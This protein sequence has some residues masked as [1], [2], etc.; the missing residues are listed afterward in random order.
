MR[1]R[2]SIPPL[3][4]GLGF[5]ALA[6]AAWVLAAS[7][8]VNHLRALRWVAIPADLISLRRDEGALDQRALARH[9]GERLVGRYRYAVDGRVFEST[10]ISFSH[11]R[12]RGL[13]DWDDEI[14]KRLG[15]EG[16]RIAVWVDPADPSSAV[17]VRDIRWAEFGVTLL[18]AILSTTGAW[19][20][21]AASRASHA[22]RDGTPPRVSGRAIAL[23]WML[24]APILTLA[25]L[26]WR[27][28]H[29]LWAST[30]TLVLPMA[31]NGLWQWWRQTRN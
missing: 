1:H 30:A 7:L 21:L 8:I 6:T 2:I 4:I 18:A 24:L 26:L 25:W 10:R 31:L 15:S 13:D 3:L 28:G 14:A 5:A 19:L 16:N 20:F 12:A 9:P 23:L 27:D 22:P 17:A 29:V 11:V